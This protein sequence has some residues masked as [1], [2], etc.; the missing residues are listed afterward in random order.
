LDLYVV[1]PPKKSDGLGSLVKVSSQQI[2]QFSLTPSYICS[3]VGEFNDG[4]KGVFSIISAEG[5]SVAPFNMLVSV[6]VSQKYEGSPFPTYIANLTRLN[7]AAT[8]ASIVWDP[9]S[10]HLVIL[11]Y[12][13]T[14]SDNV[15][16]FLDAVAN[17]SSG[18][19]MRIAQ[20]TI[21]L[22]LI[23]FSTKTSLTLLSDRQGKLSFFIFLVT[24]LNIT[25]M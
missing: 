10:N 20:Q 8:P 7:P 9:Y 12:A 19:T 1:Q 24:V 4:S 22:N 11:S 21:S 16:F 18:V 17:P 6:N 14:N 3:T 25:N 23:E 2:G 13:L 15:T 5:P